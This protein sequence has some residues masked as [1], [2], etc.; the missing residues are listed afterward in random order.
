MLS[1][2][3]IF[4]YITYWE[5]R[6]VEHWENLFT[7]NIGKYFIMNTVG[8][9]IYIKYWEI[10]Y[11]EHWEYLFTHNTGNKYS[12]NAHHKIFTNILCK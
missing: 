11:V 5:I 9:F 3:G 2:V 10:R 8:I 12:H 7:Q 1:T 4:I 6:Y